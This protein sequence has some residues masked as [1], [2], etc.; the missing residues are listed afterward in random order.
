MSKGLFWSS[1]LHHLPDSESVTDLQTGG[2]SLLQNE[3]RI[4]DMQELA[5]SEHK[6]KDQR[7]H[8]KSIMDFFVYSSPPRIGGNTFKELEPNHVLTSQDQRLIHQWWSPP[9]SRPLGRTS[10]TAE[11]AFRAFSKV[12]LTELNSLRWVVQPI[13]E[14][15]YLQLW[16]EHASVLSFFFEEISSLKVNILL[17]RWIHLEEWWRTFQYSKG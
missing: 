1:D 11:D 5:P 7:E 6:C 14:P 2:G 12:F 9:T 3:L 4:L 10:T 16:K 8:T 15:E 17:R 13:L